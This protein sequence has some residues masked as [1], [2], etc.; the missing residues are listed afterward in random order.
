MNKSEEEIIYHTKLIE[1]LFNGEIPEEKVNEI[2]DYLLSDE[3]WGKLLLNKLVG[4]MK[5]EE[6]KEWN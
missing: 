1:S 3:R 4:V 2:T 6:W 5:E